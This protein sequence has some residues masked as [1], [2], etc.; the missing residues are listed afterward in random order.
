MKKIIFSLLIL[1][2]A[3]LLSCRKNDVQPDIKQYDDEQIQAFIKSNGITGM[4]RDA[5]GIYYQIL[6]AG[7]GDQFQYKD[8]IG[9]VYTL[10]TFDG[11][12]ASVDTISNHYTGYVGHI[13]Q[14]GYPVALQTAI[15]E[16]VKKYGTK[17][18]LLVPSNLG[19]GSS[20]V[21]T[22]SSENNTRIYGNQCLDYYVNVMSNVPGDQSIYD[23][24]VIRN[25]LTANSLT[26]YSKTASGIYYK[27]LRPGVGTKA[28]TNNTTVSCNYTSLLLN[29]YIFSQA[30][31]G[32]SGVS[33]EIPD[34]IPGVSEILKSFA[35]TGTNMSIILP[36]QQAYGQRGITSSNV[37]G[38]SCIRFDVQVLNLIP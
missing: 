31:F 23:D 20:G 4:Q 28:I 35:T 33:L 37:P 30:N 8:S 25:Y 9:F 21:G 24:L 7:S 16:I 34:L 17:V 26:G 27:I 32:D 36:S 2:V 11:R 3:G 19:Y 6:K 29:G 22:G 5:S 12:Y 15:F 13:A 10:R 38:N 1:V 14:G 18:R